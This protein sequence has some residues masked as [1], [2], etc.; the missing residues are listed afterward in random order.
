LV[1]YVWRFGCLLSQID[2]QNLSS[3][4]LFFPRLALFAPLVV[5]ASAPG[6]GAKNIDESTLDNLDAAMSEVWEQ[7]FGLGPEHCPAE[8]N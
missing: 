8:S 1:S 3:F 5:D 7:R 6:P 2:F 4:D